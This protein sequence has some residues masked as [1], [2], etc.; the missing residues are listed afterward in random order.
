MGASDTPLSFEDFPS[1]MPMPEASASSGTA[2][3]ARRKKK[4]HGGVEG[5]ARKGG[6]KAPASNKGKAAA[7]SFTG[8]RTIVF[9]IGGMAYSEMRVARD[10]MARESKEIIYGSTAF[11]TA[12]DFVDD[13]QS[14]S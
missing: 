13:L 6:R 5:S 2:A 14:L 1:V 11:L 9:T 12:K 8:G 7:N 10:M 4:H 3:S